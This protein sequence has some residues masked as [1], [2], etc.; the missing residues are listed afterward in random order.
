VLGKSTKLK[1]LN[2]NPLLY[3]LKIDPLFCVTGGVGAARKSCC[4]MPDE[5]NW[6]QSSVAVSNLLITVLHF[7]KAL[8]RERRQQIL[9]AGANE[10]S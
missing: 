10:N 2:T 3:D 8:G 6:T 9:R 4:A 1:E 5:N 7:G